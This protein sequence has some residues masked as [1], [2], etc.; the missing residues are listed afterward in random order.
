MEIGFEVQYAL[1][2]VAYAAEHSKDGLIKAR[3]ISKAYGI[4]CVYLHKIMGEL[5]KANILKS[6]RGTGGGFTLARPA[7][8]ISI[9][10]IIEAVPGPFGKITK[11]AKQAKKAPFA[12]NMEKVCNDA[13][14]KARDRFQKA[15]LSKM[16]G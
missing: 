11:I 12:V 8:E 1:I 13:A 15:K 6:K 4:P 7:H 16:I 9:L 3:T 5:A 10:E 14:A 2:A